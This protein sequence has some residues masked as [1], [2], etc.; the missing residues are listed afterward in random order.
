MCKFKATRLRWRV[1]RALVELEGWCSVR[2]ISLAT[3]MAD[4]AVSFGLKDLTAGG[5]IECGTDERLIAAPR[6]G[7]YP[8]EVKV[9]RL[10]LVPRAHSDTRLS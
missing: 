9:Y 2:D 8:R 1:L 5:L 4:R 7:S 3:G 6:G 10:T